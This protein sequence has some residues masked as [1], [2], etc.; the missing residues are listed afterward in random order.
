MSVVDLDRPGPLVLND[1]TRLFQCDLD[2]DAGQPLASGAATLS[3]DELR[4]AARFHF[5]RDRIRFI[6]GRSFVRDV[7]GSKMRTR[8]GTVEFSYGAWGKPGIK[9]ND[10]CFFNVS[11]SGRWLVMV[12]SDSGP[13]GLDVELPDRKIDAL[14][15]GQSCFLPHENAILRALEGAEQRHRFL[16]FWTAKE[17]LMKLT[18]KGFSLPPKSIHLGLTNGWPTS[19]LLPIQPVAS[20]KPVTLS[21]PGQT[22]G[23]VCT[24][25]QGLPE[26]RIA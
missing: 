25:A 5:E 12:I 16:A 22:E 24:I 2:I 7:L 10:R 19:Y 6:R 17:A 15:L 1:G 21:L 23:V 26:D 11:H 20:L 13:V 8:P 18:G 4:R 14:G 9:G 3:E